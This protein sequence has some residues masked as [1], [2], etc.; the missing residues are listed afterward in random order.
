[1]RLAGIQAL[2]HFKMPISSIRPEIYYFNAI[3]NEIHFDGHKT[4]FWIRE[5][6]KIAILHWRKKSG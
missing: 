5:R 4:C 2:I 6:E 3:K 1:M